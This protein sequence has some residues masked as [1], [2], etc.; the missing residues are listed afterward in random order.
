MLFPLDARTVH[1]H[2]QASCRRVLASTVLA[3]F[4]PRRSPLSLSWGRAAGEKECSALAD[5]SARGWLL[6]K[7]RRRLASCTDR[8]KRPDN[9]LSVW[10]SSRTPAPFTLY[11]SS[12]LNAKS[13]VHPSNERCPCG[14]PGGITATLSDCLCPLLPRRLRPSLDVRCWFVVVAHFAHT[15]AAAACFA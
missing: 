11:A 10:R 2:E 15:A 6:A 3:F 9:R 1:A 8:T 7:L 14:S 12:V 13:R 4:L 5:A